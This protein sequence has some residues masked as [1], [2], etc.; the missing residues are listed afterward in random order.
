MLEHFHRSTPVECLHTILLGHYKALFEDL[1]GST[2][3]AQK[4]AVTARIS[5]FP[6]SGLEVK[7]SERACRYNV[8]LFY[9]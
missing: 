7:L 1:M 3:D 2:T 6:A 5:D 9:L 4:E 8:L